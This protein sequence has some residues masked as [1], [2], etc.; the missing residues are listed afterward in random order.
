MVVL[1]SL[2]IHVFADGFVYSFGTIIVEL[3]EQ[4]QEGKALTSW[5]VSTLIGLTLGAGP[6]FSFCIVSFMNKLQSLMHEAY[7]LLKRLI[8]FQKFHH[9]F[10]D[11]WRVL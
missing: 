8:L 2:L 6:F 9:I 1:G 7:D 4:F 3:L 5:I 11:Q 10:Q